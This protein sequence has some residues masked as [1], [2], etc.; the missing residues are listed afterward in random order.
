MAFLRCQSLLSFIWLLSFLTL[1]SGQSFQ[2]ISNSSL[3][4]VNLTVPCAAALQQIIACD[5]WVSRF[6]SGQYYDPAGLK[7]VC[8]TD[9]ETAIQDY[10][11]NVTRSC[12]DQ[13][14]NYTDSVYVP[15]SAIAEQLLYSYN[16]VCLEDAGRFCN[17]VAYQAS[18]QA[19]PDAQAIFGG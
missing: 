1:I 19:D 5:P 6:R 2:Y 17:N 10:Q 7:T 18:L 13:L 16:L 14:Y 15:V 8:T 11:S 9:C 3:P 4:S 12:S